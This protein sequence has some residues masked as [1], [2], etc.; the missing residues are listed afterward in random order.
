MKDF[1]DKMKIFISDFKSKSQKSKF[2]YLIF[3]FLHSYRDI[4]SWDNDV[5]PMLN[6]IKCGGKS[7]IDWRDFEWGGVICFRRNYVMILD[8]SIYQV[9]RKLPPLLDENDKPIVNEYFEWIENT[10]Y[11][12]SNY[13][14]Y[15]KIPMDEFISICKRWYNEVL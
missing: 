1:S 5:F 4:K 2:D 9:G 15:L 13:S 12:E 10:E 8:E 11:I 6:S 3:D 14:E 7:Q